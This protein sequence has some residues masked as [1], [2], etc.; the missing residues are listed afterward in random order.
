M[1]MKQLFGVFMEN[2]IEFENYF[3]EKVIIIFYPNG[4]KIKNKR[5][6]DEIKNAWIENLKAWH[7][8]YTCLFDLRDFNL[9]ESLKDEFEKMILFFKNF[10]MRKIIGFYNENSLKFDLKFDTVIGLENAVLRTGLSR[11]KEVPKD[12]LDL[13][14]KIQI[15]NDFNSHVIEVSFLSETEFLTP[16]DLDILKSKLQNILMLWHTP[17]HI[18][19]HCSN[20]RFSEEA[21]HSFQKLEKFL[22]SF[23]CQSIVGYAPREEKNAYPF[24]VYRSRHLAARS[25][26]SNN[27][28]SGKVA[29]CSSRKIGRSKNLKQGIIK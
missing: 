11:K 22:K 16:A 8:P 27:L 17:Y 29:T 12:V 15:E 21:K 5:D 25:L 20:C 9:D 28:Q 10:F 24:A 23:F 19:I 6:L 14:K 4:L 1:D 13:R 7:S 2:K 18:L 26:K 3:S